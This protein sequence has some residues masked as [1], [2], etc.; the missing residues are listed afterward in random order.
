MSY[1][2]HSMSVNNMYKE[3]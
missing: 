3:H 2:H 1:G